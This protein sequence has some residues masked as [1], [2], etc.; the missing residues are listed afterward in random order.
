MKKTTGILVVMILCTAI[1]FAGGSKESAGKTEKK[2]EFKYAVVYPPVGTQAEG[3]AALEGF[4]EEYS[5]GRI[6]FK[7]FPSSQL[8]DKM[9]AFEG[10]R[11]GAI[12]M[13]ECAASDLSNF[14]KIWSAF[15]LPFTFNNGEEAIKIISSPSVAKILN[16]D[17]EANGFKIIGWWNMGERSIL[18]SRRPIYKPED[19]KGL[20]IRVMQDPILAKSINAMGANGTPMAWGEVYTAVQQKVIDGLEN[21][22]PVIT[23]NKLQEVAKYYSLTQ[24][25]IIP[26]PILVSKKVFDALPGDLKEAVMKAGKAS[27][28]QFN[29]LWAKAAEKEYATLKSS[30][31]AINEVDKDAFRAAVRPMIEEFLKTADEKTKALYAAFTS[32]K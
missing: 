10:L 17:A 9:A 30:G 6:D 23:A 28:E 26:D 25:F 13:T 19:L 18:N 16:E 15:S 31:V 2:I 22:P 12:E 3:A 20:K 11:A 4:I 7:F 14:S 27:Q 5:Q 29:S 24:Q 8:G 32:G 1:I 21:S